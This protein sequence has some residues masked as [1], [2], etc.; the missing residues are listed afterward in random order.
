MDGR[1]ILP[2]LLSAQPPATNAVEVPTKRG[3]WNTAP[4]PLLQ[5]T[6]AQ[7]VQELGEDLEAGQR[8]Y[9]QQWRDAVFIEYYYNAD[10]DKCA[11]MF[12]ASVV[13]AECLH[14]R[15]M[16]MMTVCVGSGASRTAPILPCHGPQVVTTR[17]QTS[18]TIVPAGEARSA[19]PHATRPSP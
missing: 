13:L 3:A 19:P 12:S 10:N 15:C 8:R 9:L 2:L 5:A 7:L 18:I 6:H 16:V 11:A 17:A 14:A 1:S 4:L